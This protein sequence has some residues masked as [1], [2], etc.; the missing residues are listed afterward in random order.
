MT[1]TPDTR[2]RLLA[3]LAERPGEEARA[4]LRRAELQLEFARAFA[5]ALP[6]RETAGWSE[7]IGKAQAQL[8]TLDAGRGLEGLI[9]AVRAAEAEMEPIGRAAKQYAIHCVGHGHI[10]M[11]WMWSWPETVATTHDTFASILNLMEQYPE[12]TYSQ[13]QASVY[14]LME[15]YY[16][17]LFAQIQKRVEEGRWEVAAVHWV[18][19]DKNIASGESICRHLLYTRDYFRTRFGLEPEDVPVDWEPDTFGHA[20]T[21]PTILAQGAVQYYYS[22]RTGG[23]F[24]HPMIGQDRPRLF[25]WQGPDGARVLVNRESTWYNSYVNIGDNIALPLADFVKETSLHDW[26]N[27]YGLGNHGGGPTRS[28]IE[29]YLSLREWPIYPQIVFSTATRYFK[30]IEKEIAA[31]GR[32]IPVLDH[33]LNFE[34]TGCYT[35]QSAIKRGNRYGENY[36]EEAETLAALAARLWGQ[37]YPAERLREAWIN[38]LFNQFHDILPGSG[39]RQTREHAQGLFQE[40][41]AITGAIKR[42]AGRALASRI[43]T[44]SLLPDTPAGREERTLAEQ[45]AANTPFVAGAGIGAG[46]TGYSQASGGGKRFRPFIVYNSCAWPRT[47]RVTVALYDA[48]FD[49]SRVVALDE[50]GHAHPTLFLGR[51]NDWGH[52]KLT[53]AFDAQDVPPLGYRTYLLT[54]GT[55]QPAQDTVQ[56]SANE[57]FETPFLRFRLDRYRSGLLELI[58]MRTGVRILR[59]KRI[60]FGSWQ[61][62]VERPRGMTAWALGHEL[63][64]PLLLRSTHFHVIGASRNEGTNVPGEGG[65]MGYHV[66]SLLEVPGTQS[67]VRI[68]M[69]ISALEPRL[70]FT[71]DI[72][73]REI[74]DEERGIPGLVITFPVN[75]EGMTSCYEAPFGSV[76]RKLFRGEE[77][78]TLRYAHVEGKAYKSEN[79]E[80]IPVYAGVTLVQD[81]KYGHSIVTHLGCPEL[82]LRIVRSSFDP[83]HAPEVAHSSVRYSI[84]LHDSPPGPADLTRLGAA[85]NHPCLLI[86]ANLQPGDAPSQDSFA[87]VTT[88]NVVL[89]ALK[90]AE[91][92]SGLVLRLVEMNGQDTEVVVTLSPALAA[93]LTTVTLLDLMERPVAGSAAW[94]APT[95]RVPIKAHSFVTVKLS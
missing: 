93:G 66:E 26:L 14:A 60:P 87:S 23:G 8:E 17:T 6:E 73:W 39:V 35:S 81:C 82:R 3:A 72:D 59:S 55:A 43:N 12:L 41:G 63:D 52:D 65:V 75:L 16:P 47:E 68:S 56:M 11:N 78:P 40:V 48:D 70:D 13:S 36:L 19:G 79:K 2:S 29:Y 77:V 80:I 51:G 37:P 84:Y 88:P 7:R 90:Q 38:V 30:A 69:M 62:V 46:M 94:N 22:C 21:I 76:E 20:V 33:E 18:E 42:T 71:A 95:L 28:E 44:L 34:F 9:A 15:R 5:A 10:D 32:Q 74:G 92:G 1:L 83:D 24:E 61:Y 89:S 49:P 50:Q 27:V 54:E 57:W 25:Y 58:D 85:W 4:W 53:V 45:G 86:P 67:T 64:E 31:S 91:D